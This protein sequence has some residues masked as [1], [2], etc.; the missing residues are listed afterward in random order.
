MK[1]YLLICLS[2]FF[3]TSAMVPEKKAKPTIYLIGDSTVKNGQGK[4][5]GGLW[6]WGA[7]LDMF[8]DTNKVAVRNHARGGTSSS[9]YIDI[10]LW[11]NVFTRLKPGDYVI[12]QF[13]HNDNGLI[14]D[15]FRARGTI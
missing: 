10:G 13:G 1:R 15:N 5:D 12:M 8:V 11:D 2:L 9:T 7:Y 3:L 4:G 6:G 14:N